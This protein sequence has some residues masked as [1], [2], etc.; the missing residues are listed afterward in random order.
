MPWRYQPPK[1]VHSQSTV[2][3]DSPDQDSASW[4]LLKAK[5]KEQEQN[6]K[7]LSALLVDVRKIF[8]CSV[9]VLPDR[10]THTTIFRTTL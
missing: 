5:Q 2:D 1:A 7:P 4:E 9:S 3:G 8:H 6:Q 10:T